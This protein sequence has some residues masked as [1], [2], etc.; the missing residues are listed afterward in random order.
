MRSNFAWRFM[1]SYSMLSVSSQSKSPNR[2]GA[3]LMPTPTPGKRN[4]TGGVEKA[5]LRQT[6]WTFKQ[7]FR[8]QDNVKLRL[9]IGRLTVVVEA[10]RHLCVL[11]ADDALATS[12]TRWGTSN[13][14]CDVTV[15]KSSLQT[16]VSPRSLQHTREAMHRALGFRVCVW[17][18]AIKQYRHLARVIISNWQQHLHRNP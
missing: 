13:S 11:R 7:H 17:C 12:E 14:L 16:S 5:Q 18:A 6:K 3:W 1:R 4:Q 9:D 15:L 8:S 2:S 10:V